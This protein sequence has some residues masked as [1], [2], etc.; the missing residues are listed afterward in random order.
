MFNPVLGSILSE[1]RVL[2]AALVKMFVK[3]KGDA[4]AD[5]REGG[6]CGLWDDMV[7][8]EATTPAGEAAEDEPFLNRDSEVRDLGHVGTVYFGDC[9]QAGT[10][11]DNSFVGVLRRPICIDSCFCF[12]SEIDTQWLS[13][14]LHREVDER[15]PPDIEISVRHIP[16]FH[17]QDPTTRAHGFRPRLPAIL[18]GLPDTRR[19][20]SKRLKKDPW[21]P[22]PTL[23]SPFPDRHG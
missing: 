4:E 18:P 9:D 17:C 20:T 8:R 21:A 12:R 1:G 13:Q 6:L 11:T 2:D 15:K 19:K 3:L 10:C 5:S 7:A 22:T 14:A 16:A 23:I